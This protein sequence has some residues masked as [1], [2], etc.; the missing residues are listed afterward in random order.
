MNTKPRLLTLIAYGFL[1]NDNLIGVCLS[2]RAATAPT[3]PTRMTPD[4]MTHGNDRRATILVSG[5]N[6]MDTTRI[7]V[8]VPAFN[9]ADT[10]A[11][12][13]RSILAS[14]LPVVVVDDGSTDATAAEAHLAGAIILQLPFNLGVGG[15][16]R[17]G[18][19]WAI[20][21]GFD[22]VIQCDADGQHDPTEMQ[23][24]IESACDA[25]AHLLVGSR[26]ISPQGFRS[27][28][29]RRI[30]MRL[31]A[32]IASRSVGSRISDAS[33]GFRVIRQPLLSEFARAYPVHYLGDTFEVLVQAG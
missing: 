1:N 32:G 4:P 23:R 18:F 17:C 14:G 31:L 13:V 33:S 29:L 19:R 20:A 27:T 5:F 12:V 28:G 25:D 30:S 8:L 15:A 24:L 16:L 9:E 3:T 11:G 26:F 7:V 21:N 10:V 6:T 22:T 2:T